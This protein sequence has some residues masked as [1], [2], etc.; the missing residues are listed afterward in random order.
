MRPFRD[1][2]LGAALEGGGGSVTTTTPL[3]SQNPQSNANGGKTIANLG[4][5]N[6]GFLYKKFNHTACAMLSSRDLP[7]GPQTCTK[8][9]EY[10]SNQTR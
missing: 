3:Q 9:I 1:L 7:T 6:I 4:S 5:A 10:F 2:G 8:I